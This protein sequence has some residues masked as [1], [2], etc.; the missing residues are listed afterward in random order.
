MNTIL[1]KHIISLILLI[2]VAGMILIGIVF[3]FSS[4]K[5]KIIRVLETKERIS[6]YQKNKKEFADEV[7]KLKSF[8]ERIVSLES[9]VVGSADV[10]TL[11][12]TFENLAQDNVAGFEI[13][14]VQ[15]PVVDEKMK[16]LVDFNVKGSYS[17]IQAFFNKIQHQ[18][19]QVH[20]LELAIFSDQVGQVA[21][22]ENV[23]SP[24][25]KTKLPVL[26]KEKSWQA[27]A[28]IEILS[29]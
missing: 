25:N 18:S 28:T 20:F 19:F 29:F 16:L 27:A 23:I 15:T 12:S 26:P 4:M 21:E 5:T 22:V 13:V 24:D 7:L 11:L 8:E 10:P 3:L 2:V 6:S 9:K 1:K 17:Q 14:S